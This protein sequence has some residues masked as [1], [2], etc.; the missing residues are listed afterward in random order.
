M[1]R[2]WVLIVAVVLVAA[3]TVIASFTAQSGLGELAGWSAVVSVSRV[4][5]H[6][7]WLLPLTVDAYGV[8]ATRIATNK[9]A[10][11]AE[12]RRQAFGHALAAVAVSVVANAVYHLIEA[13]VIVLGSAAWLLVVA[14]SIV[15]PV[16]LGGLAHLLS[17]AARDEVET[18]PDAVPGVPAPVGMAPTVDV[19][20][21]ENHPEITSPE[22]SPLPSVLGFPFPVPAVY[23]AVP[24]QLTRVLRAG[25]PGVSETIEP[26]A[27]DDEVRA[28]T[29]VPEHP[30]LVQKAVE[31][32]AEALRSGQT[33]AVREIKARLGVGTDRAREVRVYLEELTTTAVAS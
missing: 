26:G 24:A 1:R 29:P 31:E 17:V 23:P 22:D 25:K 16:A 30:P 15:P 27:V 32:F 20:R 13:H 2:D 28:G 12:V 7:S 21:I 11:S 4:D 19:E 14:V 5:L 10:Y 8:A 9:R 6:L 18:V 33:P 3:S